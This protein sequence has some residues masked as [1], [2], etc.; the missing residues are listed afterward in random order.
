MRA[1]EDARPISAQPLIGRAGQRE[2]TFD[3]ELALAAFTTAELAI[4]PVALA[5]ALRE[6]IGADR[7]IDVRLNHEVL[8]VEDSNGLDVSTDTSGGG[9][10]ERLDH[11]VN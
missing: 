2:A 6:R 1:R 8:S 5:E 10:R 9:V 11:V 7:R 3:P 4:D